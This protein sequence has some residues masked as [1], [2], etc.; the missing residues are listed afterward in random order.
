MLAR[1]LEPEV[2]DTPEEAAD[3]DAMDHREVNRV[4]VGDFLGVW[5]GRG[6]VLD[7]GTGTAQIPIELCRTTAT[8]EVVAIDLAEH[9]L[10]LGRENVRRAGLERRI[11]LRRADAKQL[12]FGDEEFG[13][14]MSNSIVHHIPEPGRVLREMVRV[15][16]RGGCVFV[17]DLLRPPDEDTVNYLVASYAKDA[18]D[19]QQQMF[20][21]S[22]RA[23]LTLA[24][25]RDL[26]AGLGFDPA[27]VQQ[28][29]DRHWTWSARRP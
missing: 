9:M 2:M 7:V 17:R 20:A 24:E 25:V 12:P 15:V 18:N 19:H 23:A 4:F 14:V 6:P 10:R 5:D 13:A 16:R 21:A 27:T 8:A 1:I 29:S 11:D 28:T 22:L 3:Y 26:V